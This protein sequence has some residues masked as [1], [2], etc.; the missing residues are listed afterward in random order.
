V[1]KVLDCQALCTAA[2]MCVGRDADFQI[3]DSRQKTYKYFQK[4]LVLGR[5]LLRFLDLTTHQEVPKLFS[6]QTLRGLVDKTT[7]QQPKVQQFE[8]DRR[9]GH[10]VIFLLKFLDLIIQ[11]E[12]PNLKLF[13]Q[14]QQNLVHKTTTQQPKVQQFE[15]AGFQ[16]VQAAAA[17][18]SSN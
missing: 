7:A 16:D 10:G 17:E 15:S 18:T 2:A 6:Q 5:F 4:D 8:T 13:S 3:Q 11:E 9:Q 12:A 1:A 14:Q